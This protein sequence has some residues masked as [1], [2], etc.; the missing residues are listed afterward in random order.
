MIR[1]SARRA[2]VTTCPVRAGLVALVSVAALGVVAPSLA[3]AGRAKVGQVYAGSTTQRAPAVLRLTAHGR[4]A[5]LSVAW[6]GPCQSGVSAQQWQGVRVAVAAG[7]FTTHVSTDDIDI[8]ASGTIGAIRASGT[9]HV[10]ARYHDDAGNLV[11]TCDSGTV[12]WNASGSAW[13]GAQAGAGY[14]VALMLSRSGSEVT[15]FVLPFEVPCQGGGEIAGSVAPTG[16]VVSR[17]GNFGYRWRTSQALA[18]GRQLTGEFRLRGRFGATAARGTWS[19]TLTIKGADGQ[20]VDVCQSGT[21]AWTA[22]R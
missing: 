2:P 21:L 6:T 22:W 9:W 19:A 17:S 18:D 7:K 10:V 20:P 16:L 1:L 13:G 4:L 14:P 12:R 5:T 3:A 15:K 11:D 8:D